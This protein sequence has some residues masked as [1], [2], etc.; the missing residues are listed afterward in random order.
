[1]TNRLGW[2]LLSVYTQDC[3]KMNY[4]QQKDWMRTYR[5]LIFGYPSNLT[6]NTLAAMVADWPI[7][8]QHL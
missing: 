1:V 5:W 2:N 6:D 7:A 3:R 4:R 8:A